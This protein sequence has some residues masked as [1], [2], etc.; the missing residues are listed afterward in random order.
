M[1]TG[2]ENIAMIHPV[3]DNSDESAD[4][5]DLWPLLTIDASPNWLFS[6]T[7]LRVNLF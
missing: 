4:Y 7:I 2:M 5:T 1:R 6:V 3:L